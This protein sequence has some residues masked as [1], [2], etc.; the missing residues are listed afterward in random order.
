MHSLGERLIRIV[1]TCDDI[2]CCAPDGVTLDSFSVASTITTQSTLF[3][4]ELDLKLLRDPLHRLLAPLNTTLTLFFLLAE[5]ISSPQ[6]RLVE[7]P[8]LHLENPNVH[9]VS[10]VV[11][12]Y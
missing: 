3:T 6:S 2:Y 12:T 4:L 7:L 9:T 8:M 1:I 10:R 5:Q 11:D